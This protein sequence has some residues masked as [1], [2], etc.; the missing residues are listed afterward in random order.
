MLTGKLC[1]ISA[2]FSKNQNFKALSC[3]IESPPT[4]PRFL[5]VNRREKILTSSRKA[6]NQSSN[7]IYEPLVD[8][9]LL[10]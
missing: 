7:G 1:R 9:L 8:H 6:K 4:N 10:M 3:S 2:K 5:G